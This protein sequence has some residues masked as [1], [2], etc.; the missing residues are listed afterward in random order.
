MNLMIKDIPKSERPRERLL[1]YGGEILSN[2]EILSIILKSGTKGEG[3]SE[4][5]NKVLTKIENISNLK[6]INKEM[7][8]SIKGI[9]PTKAIEVLAAIELG[10]RIFI[11]NEIE[12][13]TIYT[14]SKTIY[15]NN[16]SLFYD[17]KQEYFYCIYLD[18]KRKVIERK[19][20]FMG[21][22]NKSYVHPREIFKEAHLLSAS[23]IICM[24]NHPSGDPTP[25]TDDIILTKSL[26]EIGRLQQIPILDHII[27]G[28]NNYYSFYEESVID[29]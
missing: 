22:L 20:L 5:A 12:T 13:N 26:L 18:Q 28:D 7:L 9:G 25:S 11:K 4:L 24:H 21:T 17:K 16:K 8:T 27:F 15:N 19:L 1:K 6:N 2:N 29:F 10:K 3:V 14:N 23:A